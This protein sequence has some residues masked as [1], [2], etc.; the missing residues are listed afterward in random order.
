MNET[1]IGWGWYNDLAKDLIKN[2][3]EDK[4]FNAPVSSGFTMLDEL[5][6][7]GFKKGELIILSAPTKQGK[8]TLAQT[9]SWNMAKSGKTTLW[10]TMEMSWQELTKKFMA[11]DETLKNDRIPSHTPIHYPMQNCYSGG[12]LQLNWLRET[13]S[14]AIRTSQTEFVVIDHLHFLLPLKDF[15]TNTSFLIGGIVREIKKMA[16]E[17]QIPIMLIAHTTKLDIEKTPDINSIRD[18]SFIAQ[19]SDFTMIMWRI[20]D[21][22]ALK[23]TNDDPDDDQQIVFTNKAWLSLEA[24]RRTGQTG[25]IKLWHDGTKFV[26]F[27]DEHK[28]MDFGQYANSKLKQT[29]Y[30]LP[31]M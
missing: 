3:A 11:M 8:T 31:S 17:L 19:E 23:K 9:M 15:N 25:R 4:L 24:N 21:K 30:D 10:F 27:G 29:K 18:S 22:N 26:P 2:E 5:L 1:P 14:E 20:R 28:A 12:Q 16:V 6:G 7:G 13:I